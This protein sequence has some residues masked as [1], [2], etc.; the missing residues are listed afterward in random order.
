MCRYCL[1]AA[2]CD[3]LTDENDLSFISIGE[4]VNS[5]LYICSGDGKGVYLLF[6]SNDHKSG[7]IYRPKFCPECGRRIFENKERFQ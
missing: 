3:E 2:I 1:T 5:T 4:P 7:A 6:D